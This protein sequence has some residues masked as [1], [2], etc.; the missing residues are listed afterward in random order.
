MLQDEFRVQRPIEVIE[1]GVDVDF[2]APRP[3]VT[4]CPRRLVFLGSLDWMPNIDGAQWFVRDA[5][6]RIRSAHPDTTLELVGRRPTP[7]IHRLVADDPSI[8]LVPD[9]PDVRQHIAQADLFIVPLRIGGGSRIKIYEAMSMGRPVVA[10]RVGAEG[11]D[12]EPGTHFAETAEDPAAFADQIVQLLNDPA[13]KQ[14]LAQ[15]GYCHVV[16]NYPW[17]QIAQKFHRLCQELVLPS[18]TVKS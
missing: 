1:T 14:R 2:F 18:A 11:L 10:T 3:H 9:V 8:R 17:N 6:P 7:D 4:P 12:L 16:E 13:E 5:Y 15:Q